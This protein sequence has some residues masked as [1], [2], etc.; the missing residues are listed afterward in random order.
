MASYSD[1]HTDLLAEVPGVSTPLATRVLR[2]VVRDFCKRTD[3]YQ[4][5]LSE[6]SIISGTQAYTLSDPANNEII[7]LVKVQKADT[8][9]SRIF[10]KQFLDY[11][12]DPPTFTLQTEPTENFTLEMRASL[13]PDASSTTVDDII[14]DNYYD[15][16][17]VGA[18]ARLLRMQKLPWTD[19]QLANVYNKEYAD[20]IRKARIDLNKEFTNRVITINQREWV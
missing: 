18:S 3:C 2:R 10:K 17:I 1:F 16:I 19:M 5:D 9:D 15:G 4:A 13:R 7:R 8:N 6:L 12:F 20:Y 14:Y 11:I